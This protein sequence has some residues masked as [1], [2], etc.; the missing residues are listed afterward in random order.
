MSFAVPPENLDEFLRVAKERDVEATVLG[1]F[2]DDGKFCILYGDRV[3]ACLDISFMHD[4]LPRLHLKA[5]WEPKHFE[6]PDL[7]GRSVKADV[8]SMLGRLNICSCEYKARQYDHE[9][10]GLS[11]I[12]P[13]TGVKNDVASDATV[14][15]IE[16][17][18]TEGVVLSAGIMPRYSD[19][20][21]YHMMASTMDVAIRQAV[22]VGADPS[23][24]AGLDNFCWPDP[25]QSEKTPDG[26]YKLAQLVRANQA[27]YDYAIAFTVPCVSGKDSMKNDSTRGG[28]KIS[29]PPT[30][31]FSVMGKINDISK[32][33]SIDAKLAGDA[34]CMIGST[35]RELGGSEYFAMLGK[36]GNDV[37]KV[38]AD[39]ANRTYAAYYK[40]LNAGLFHS[41]ISPAIGGLAI[42]AARA[43]MG[44]RLGMTIR[45]DD[46]P[47]TGNLSD[48]ET[49][50]SESNSRFLVTCAKSDVPRLRE[51]FAGI[52]FAE[53]GETNTG[54]SLEFVSAAG[55]V[56]L[57]LEEM[58]ASY[59]ATLAGV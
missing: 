46:V 43:A 17:L 37:P 12:K 15:M 52:P 50:F 47:K 57:P 7:T 16:P 13:Y 34:V 19:I 49:L 20:D 59:K 41:S 33:V 11:V 9:V 26:E 40:A 8:L 1:E 23:H 4:G 2:T 3:V 38:D 5:V 10:K 22:A 42:A 56:D 45:L 51:I 55:K 21:T 14:F 39:L 48:L 58:V 53:I 29:I 54:N 31:L 28:R 44:G 25:V 35:K 32:A 24:L 36:V 27:L 6:E 18:S 30:V